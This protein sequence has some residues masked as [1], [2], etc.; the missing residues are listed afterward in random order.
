[1]VAP[2]R[3]VSRGPNTLTSGEPSLWRSA[4]NS[5]SSQPASTRTRVWIT[6]IP[7]ASTCSIP[8]MTA[9]NPR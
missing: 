4:A 7:T 6:S 1:M 3:S 8:M 5:S 9:G 2:L